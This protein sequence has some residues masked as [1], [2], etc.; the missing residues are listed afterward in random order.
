MKKAG[1]LLLLMAAMLVAVPAYNTALAA[2]R[3]PAQGQGYGPGPDGPGYGPGPGWQHPAVNPEQ[4]AAYDK[5]M[6]PYRE[7]VQPLF[8]DMWAKQ[9]E[10][11]YLSSN[12]KADAKTIQKL[13]G[14][15][16]EL[17]GKI[18]A[19]HNSTAGKLVKDLGISHDHAHALLYDGHHG[20]GYDCG[21]APRGHWG[22]HWGGHRGG[23]WHRGR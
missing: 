11:N 23:G 6:V 3:V 19:L 20:M 4:Q 22:G 21:Y 12:E 16:K 7:Q 8:N 9:A 17:R 2:Q 10:L 1:A 5:I 14:D 18:Q 13:V 15:M